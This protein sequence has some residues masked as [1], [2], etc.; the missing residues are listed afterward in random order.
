MLKIIRKFE[1]AWF[2][3]RGL[4]KKTKVIIIFVVVGAAVFFINA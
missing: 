3:W 2:T 4:P 1:A